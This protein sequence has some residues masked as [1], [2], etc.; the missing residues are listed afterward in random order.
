[1]E[2]IELNDGHLIPK[3]GCGTSRYGKV[4]ADFFA[5]L[6]GDTSQMESAL[7]VGFR[8]FD[9][10]IIYRNEDLIPK[11][12]KNQGF[13]RTDIYIESKIDGEETYI[14]T[15]QTVRE[16][17]ES[18]L[19]KLDTDY[20][21]LYLIHR[22]TGSDEENLRVW[23]V[24]ESYHE[25]DILKSIGVSNFNV[26]E[27]R[28]L[29]EH[30]KIKP[31]VNQIKSNP[32]NWHTD[33]IAFCKD[34][35]VL[36]QIYSPLRSVDEDLRK[37]LSDIGKP[38]HKTWAQVLLRYHLDLGCQVIPMSYDRTHQAQNLDILDFKLSAADMN[39]I[40]T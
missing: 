14:K 8:M 16:S 33:I 2:F 28:Y 1:M 38:W 35:G 17:I 39:S 19:K 34:H 22:P 3:I 40:R 15:D 29:L 23:R 6:N 32:S 5:A 13:K 30:A 36:P 21:D 26:S 37:K 20:I 18:S 25:K 12:M 9:T 4:D 11:A 27:L 10:A 7:A 31:S 24:L